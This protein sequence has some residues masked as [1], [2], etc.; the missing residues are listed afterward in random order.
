MA[1]SARDAEGEDITLDLLPLHLHLPAFRFL[2]QAR[3]LLAAGV[4][5]DTEWQ[6]IIEIL[7]QVQ[8]RRQYLSWR[9]EERERSLVLHPDSFRVEGDAVAGSGRLSRD[10][11]RWRTDGG[12]YAAWLQILA[13][14]AARYAGVEGEYREAVESAERSTLPTLRDA[15]IALLGQRQPAPEEPDAGAERL[16][17]ELLIDLRASGAT[18]TTRLDQAT[19]TLQNVLFSARAGRLA[20]DASGHVWTVGTQASD[21]QEFDKQWDWMGSYRGWWAAM[22]AF[23]YPDN[24]LFPSLYVA[25]PLL[26]PP[27]AAYGPLLESLRGEG[28]LTPELAREYAAT[29]L[30]GLR[31]SGVPLEAQLQVSLNPDHQPF[32]ITDQRSN[33]DLVALQQLSAEIFNIGAQH[34]R[35]I[36]WLVPMALAA[37][38][39]QAGHFRAALDWYQTVFAYHLPPANRKIYRGLPAEADI[40]SDYARRTDW[41]VAQ[42]N[43]HVLARTRRNCYTRATVMAIVGCFLAY[44]DAEF[45][46]G[47]GEAR[48]RARTLYEAASDLLA[49]PDVTPGAVGVSPFPS[50]PIWES[51]RQQAQSN[52]SKIHRGLSIAGV[53]AAELA[54][55]DRRGA[56]LPSQYRYAV[57]IERAK[58]LVAL[59]Q[60]VESAFLAA[61][62][63]RDAKTYDELQARHSLQV[64]QSSLVLADLKATDANTA[65]RLAHLQREKALIQHDHYANQLREGLSGWEKTGLA[66]MAVATYLQASAGVFFASSALS[67]TAKAIVSFGIWGKPGE[68]VG[69][70]LSAFAGAAS[71]FGHI[72]QTKAGYDRRTQDWRLQ[73]GLA[74]KDVEIGTQQIQL[75]QNQR[76]IAVQERRLAGQQL[77]HAESVAQFLSTKFTNA[78]LYEWMSRVLQGAYA[79]F[80]QQATALAQLAEAQLAF[81]RQEFPPGFVGADYWRDTA[82][83]DAATGTS[84]S[85]DRRGLTG[86]VRLLQDIYRLDQ[87]AFETD[88]RKLHVSHTLALSQFA[89]NELQR[90]RDT[91]VLTFATPMEIFDRSFPGH[92]LRLIRRLRLSMV[93]LTPQGVNATLSASGVSRV[94]V[95]HDSFTTVAIHR[96]PESIAFTSPLN[97][98]GLLEMEPDSGMLRPFEGMGVDTVWQLELPKPANPFDYRTIAD[99]LL[100][101]EYTALDSPDYR[102]RVTRTLDRRF[103]G[104]RSFSLRNQFPDAWYDLGNADLVEDP[105]RRMRAVLTL[106]AA[107]FPPHIQDLAVT[108]L[109]LFA[110][111]ADELADELTVTALRRSALGGQ[112]VEAGEVHTVGGVVGTRRPGG[113]PWQ[114]FIGGP[115]TG[116]WELQLEDTPIVRSWFSDGKIEDLVVVFTLSGTTPPW[117]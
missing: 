107:D 42:L 54:G 12:T 98:T 90:F 60:Q 71:T 41:L 2:A 93:A 63:Q 45:S 55:A 80:L 4:R 100:T 105:N 66:S 22:R 83:I 17:R 58:N 109:T 112:T 108:H 44:G 56:F 26:P 79:Y 57:L 70:A 1:L 11:A 117:P 88:R 87:Y 67:E 64:A 8:K 72:A 52:L 47:T 97:A 77:D 35:E 106:T 20:A 10:A 15:L 103:T 92:Y 49:M 7:T 95:P 16:T 24:Q 65:V 30:T 101:I 59:A 21:E 25:D 74:G 99:V 6:D 62:E 86:S 84:D 115:A 82:T 33:R 94:V 85:L 75:A 14:R 3:S 19:E 43:P 9:R 104:D 36:F 61:L 68:G 73:Q 113:L 50:D 111:R 114:T 91:G 32:V 18:R 53:P 81:E 116:N 102:D 31:E 27:T 89:A 51:L 96:P 5:L 46:R 38:L 69:Q 23:A 29:Y 110:V 48:A 39:Q 13:G 34:Q 78:E 40:Q 28:R 76:Q 37:S